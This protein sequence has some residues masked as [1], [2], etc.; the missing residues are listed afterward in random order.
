MDTIITLADHPGGITAAVNEEAARVA[1]V[2]DA[3]AAEVT[4]TVQGWLTSEEA[5]S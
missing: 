2:M 1:A 5:L 4:T 3:Y